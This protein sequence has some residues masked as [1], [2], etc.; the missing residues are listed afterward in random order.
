MLQQTPGNNNCYLCE[1]SV[2]II[3][4]GEGREFTL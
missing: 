2:L 1:S 3:G 4:Y